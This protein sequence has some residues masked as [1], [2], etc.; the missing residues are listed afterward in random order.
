M[1]KWLIFLVLGLL[2][3]STLALTLAKAEDAGNN[4]TGLGDS[5]NTENNDTGRGNN[6]NGT[7]A[8]NQTQSQNETSNQGTVVNQTRTREQNRTNLTFTPWQ[9]RNESE[10]MEGCKCVGAVVSC[11]T[12]T[13]KTMTITVGRS[14]NIIVITV[15]R[16]NATTE[17]E[18]EAETGESNET[19]LKLKLSN[20]EKK[21]LK[22]L[23]DEASEKA[24]EKLR[25]RECN[26][27]NNC[28]LELVEDDQQLRYEVQVERHSK[29][30]ALFKKKMQVRAEVDAETGEVEVK[31]PWWAF[32]ATEPE[33]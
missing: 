1:K 20:G 24:R 28:S 22:I 18:V 12:E 9:K 30:L 2:F 3:A 6:G 26:S 7:Q 13:G 10:C 32:L 5:N 29:I 14:G 27:N 33:E 21:Q 4:E 31:K 11:E 23:P 17:M 8:Q 19:K 15:E 25:I 16:T